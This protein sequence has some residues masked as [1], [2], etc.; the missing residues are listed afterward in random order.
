MKGTGCNC[1]QFMG[2]G[3]EL[4]DGVVEAGNRQ[5]EHEEICE[6]KGQLQLGTDVI[7][8]SSGV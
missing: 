5:M 4:L 7:H 3:N 2:K 1:F 8:G 6:Y